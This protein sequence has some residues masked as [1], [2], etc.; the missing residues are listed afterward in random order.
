MADPHWTPERVEERLEAAA[1]ALRRLP[2]VRVQGHASTWPAVIREFHEAYGWDETRLRLGPPSPAAIDAMDEAL[3]WFAW[4]TPDE[5]RIVWLR[6]CRVRWKAVAWRFRADRS[7]VW[8]WWVCAL[9]KIAARL[10][11]AETAAPR[12]RHGARLRGRKSLRG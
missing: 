2:P 10:N 5:A 1:D 3:A 9:A 8:R 12:G 7:T 4:L 11:G 6:A